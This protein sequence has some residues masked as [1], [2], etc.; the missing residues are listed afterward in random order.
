MRI[1]VIGAGVAG[2]SFASKIKQKYTNTEVIILEKNDE[3]LKKLKVTGNGRCN[4]ANNIITKDKY[5]DKKL[6]DKLF[7][8]DNIKHFFD[9]LNKDLGMY[10]TEINDYLYPNS[11]SAE[12]VIY[13]YKYLIEKL[14]IKVVYN[15]EFIDLIKDKDKLVVITDK[16]NYI[17]D[18]VVFST[19]SSIYYKNYTNNVQNYLKK[20]NIKFKEFKNSLTGFKLIENVSLLDGLRLKCEVILKDKDIEI[21]REFGEVNFKSDG[22]SGIVIMNASSVYNWNN[23]NRAKLI[24]N[25]LPKKAD[26]TLFLKNDLYVNFNEKLSNYLLSRYKEEITDEV[27]QNIEFNVKSLYG[28]LNSQVANGGV[29]IDELNDDFSLKSDKRILFLGELTNMDGVC[30]GYNLMYCILSGIIAGE[31]NGL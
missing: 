16:Q 25:V 1:I 14:G 7:T 4:I 23:L 22:I 19:G 13:A 27:L 11:L 2:L 24:L 9:F 18:K 5:N 6:F 21:F 3:M 8:N 31:K 17:A 10:L 28:S 20:S 26:K 15:T 30:G 12:S 29:L